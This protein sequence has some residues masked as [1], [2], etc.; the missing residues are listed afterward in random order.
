LSL[1]HDF[2]VEWS[3]FTHGAADFGATVQRDYFPYFTQGKT[4]T[5]T[6]LE[7]YG[8]DMKHHVIGGDVDAA[9]RDL[10]D[11]DKLAFTVSIPPDPAGPTQALVR[12]SSD[13][14]LVVRYTL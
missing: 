5:I 2:P 10:A 8:T 3:R 7:V 14:F 9:S 12:N 13:A 6:G 1:R 11:Q 4:V